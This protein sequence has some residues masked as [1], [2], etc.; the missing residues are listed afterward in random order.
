MYVHE[1]VLGRV[2]G[3]YAGYKNSAELVINAKIET[4]V[5]REGL[6]FET[7]DHRKI[8]TVTRLSISGAVWNRSKTDYIIGGQCREALDNMVS[9]APRWNRTKV[10]RLASHWENWHLNDMNAACD[11]QRN[12]A[13]LYSPACPVTGYKWG[14]SWLVRELPEGV[15]ESMTELF[16]N[17]APST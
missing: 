6:T 1:Y 3:E 2:S 9:Y 13:G 5:P 16:D 12:D 10:H 7:T 8:E 15:I 14:H 17:S 11:H 4:S